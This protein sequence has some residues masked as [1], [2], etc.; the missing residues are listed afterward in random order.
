MKLTTAPN[1]YTTQTPTE[2][3]ES[4][5]TL[6][7][8]GVEDRRAGWAYYNS[9]HAIKVATLVLKL[10]AATSRQATIDSSRIKDQPNT[11]R[12]RIMQG[13]TYLMCKGSD[14]L[15]DHFMA[16]QIATILEH[17]KDLEVSVRRFIISIRLKE[18][19]ED[20]MEGIVILEAN[21]LVKESGFKEDVFRAEL[22]NFVNNAMA[23][24]QIEFNNLPK[25]ALEYAHYIAQQDDSII[26]EQVD[27]T[28]IVM[29]LSP[30][31]KAQLNAN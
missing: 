20:F 28:T 15:K 7:A 29:K 9:A 14:C 17:V 23:E 10:T 25:T 4:S 8:A 5:R 3:I 16:D 18:S 19:T 22:L 31:T 24:T 30:E 13:R 1:L 26:V 27:L 2:L 11:I 6:L 12:A 21:P